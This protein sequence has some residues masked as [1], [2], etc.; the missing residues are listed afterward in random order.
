MRVLTEA[1]KD[2]LRGDILFP[3]YFV[4]AE[5]ASGDLRLWTGMGT[6]TAMGE[7]WTG[8]GWLL[9]FSQVEETIDT[10]ATQL[11]IGLPANSELVSLMLSSFQKYKP[12]EI[13]Q[14]LLSEV[15]G[16]LI[17]D[18]VQ[19]FAG[20]AD[21]FEIDADPRKPVIRARYS[22]KMADLERARERRQTHEDQ[23]IDHSGDRFY[24]F[25][26]PLGDKVTRWGPS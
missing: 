2:A 12:I 7:E 10:H 16:S 26:G 15:D 23:Q 24:E 19:V 20:V 13:W 9:G 11:T 14:G 25:T 17:A 21:V 4:H 5:F 22:S 18:P 3:I 1:M 6:R 8:V